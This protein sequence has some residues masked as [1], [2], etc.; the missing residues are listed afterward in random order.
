MKRQR[1]LR[2]LSQKRLAAITNCLSQADVSR[3][4]SGLLLP[5]DK[6]RKAIA[7]VLGLAPERILEHVEDPTNG[8]EYVDSV[9]S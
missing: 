3:M 1:I 6:Q 7:N 5:T 8:E 4:E 9:R 2:E